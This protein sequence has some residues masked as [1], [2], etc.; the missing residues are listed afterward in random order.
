MVRVILKSL[1]AGVA[2]ASLFFAFFLPLSIAGLALA[3]R[4][5][6][7]VQTPSVMV[8]PTHFLQTVGLPLSGAAFLISFALGVRRF[9]RARPHQEAR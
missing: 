7:P 5:S 2:G 1:L 6:G 4:L 8:T 9:R 3:S